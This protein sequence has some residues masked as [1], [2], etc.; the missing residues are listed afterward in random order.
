MV[1][2]LFVKFDRRAKWGLLAQHGRKE[3]VL[4]G[5]TTFTIFYFSSLSRHWPHFAER[6]IK[7]VVSLYKFSPLTSRDKIR[8]LIAIN[9]ISP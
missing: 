5:Q 1:Q 7:S 2:L 8:I 6:P 3:S 9:M 4:H